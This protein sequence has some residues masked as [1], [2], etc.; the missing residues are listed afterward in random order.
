MLI[1]SVSLQPSRSGS[2]LI[3]TQTRQWAERIHRPEPA[4]RVRIGMLCAR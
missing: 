1:L 4:I 2:R 3:E